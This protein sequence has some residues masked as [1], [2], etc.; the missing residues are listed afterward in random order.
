MCCCV[1]HVLCCIVVY[2]IISYYVL[3][4][5][6][7]LCYIISYYVILYYIKTYYVILYHIILCCSMLYYMYINLDY[8]RVCKTLSPCL[9]KFQLSA[10]AGEAKAP[11]GDHPRGILAH[12]FVWKAPREA[13]ITKLQ[14]AF[15]R[16][17][18]VGRLPEHGPW[19]TL[20]F[21]RGYLVYVD[22][23]TTLWLWLT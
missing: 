14:V 23:V 6:I 1:I 15:P 16:Q 4:Y 20:K 19:F 17:Q 18:D 10:Q 5:H 7:I 9:D 12:A 11:E 22:R 3:L 21:H 13:K 2:H 8:L